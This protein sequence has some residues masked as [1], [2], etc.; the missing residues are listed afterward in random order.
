M[1]NHRT[2]ARIGIVLA[3]LLAISAAA[4]SGEPEPE[5]EVG[6]TA[7]LTV[8]APEFPDQN[9]KN[10]DFT[11]KMAKKFNIKFTF[12]TTTLDG[13]PAAE[14]RQIAIASG[15]Y[16]DLFLLV[17]WVDQFKAPELLKLGQQG[18]ALPLNDLINEHGPNIKKAL[19]SNP[20]F[21]AMA[22]A[23]DGKIYGLPQ[24]VDCYHCSY[25][26]KL[27]MNSQWLEKLG[28]EQPTTTEELREV[29]RA[30]KTKDPNGNGKADEV[31]L[32]A[33]VRDP[34]LPYLMNSFIYD[35]QGQSPSRD[36]TLVLNNGKVDIQANKDGWREG[37]R[38]IKSLYEEGLIDK[39]AFTQN[40][41]ALQQLGDNA[42][43]VILGSAVVMHPGIFVTTGQEDKRDM[44]YDAVPPLTGPTGVGYAGY[45]FPSV[46]GATFVLTNKASKNDQIAAIKM[47]DYIFT[48]EGQINGTEGEEG[49]DW[50]YAEEGDLALNPDAEPLYKILEQEEAVAEKRDSRR[51]IALAQYN[52]TREFRDRLV[53]PKDIYT[54]AG[55]ER[56][57][58]EATDLYAGKEDP[59]QIYP[60]WGVWINPAEASEA[61]SLTTNIDNYV[62]Q[63]SLA[64]I[65][66]S[67]NIDTEWDAYV[68]GF[69]GLG[70]PRY[71]QIQQAAYDKSDVKKG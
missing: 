62:T 16:P 69:E 60:F 19:N 11:K 63:N 13:G 48:D 27:W 56:R 1:F 6:G 65:T 45:S 21:K 12:Q 18:V 35:P 66:G 8:F 32:S 64:F 29:L 41:E 51:W 58:Q 36:S 42:D 3:G 70:L 44:Q 47:L 40:P 20:D 53:Q 68:A 59:N 15:D 37:L 46:P 55:Y 52:N 30:F 28:L 50:A 5:E 4:C 39:G 31:P 9:L 57:L 24:W 54:T 25:P 14:K 38:Y 17:P 2:R 7:N 23:P 49:V 61:A 26:T 67:K 33:N 43:T 34:L 10:N 71:L 22:T